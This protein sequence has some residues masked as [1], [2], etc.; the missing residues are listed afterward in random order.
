MILY[1]YIMSIVLGQHLAISIRG[2]YALSRS[3]GI[4]GSVSKNSRHPIRRVQWGRINVC[5]AKC[6][7]AQVTVTELITVSFLSLH[8][9][10]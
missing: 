4:V 9:Y 3:G 5:M 1:S 2:A 8:V 7:T 10:M 6:R